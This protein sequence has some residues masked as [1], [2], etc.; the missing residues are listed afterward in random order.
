MLSSKFWVGLACGFLAQGCWGAEVVAFKDAAKIKSWDA[1]QDHLPQAVA[2]NVLQKEKFCLTWQ[3]LNQ[4]NPGLPELGRLATRTSKEIAGSSWSIGCETLDR[5]YGDWDAYKALL[6]LLGVKHARFFSGWAKTEQK[7]GVYDFAWLDRQ[8]RE[9]SEMG[10]KPWI[11]LSYG[12][13]VWGS[14]F[15]L[16]MRVSQITGNPEALEAWLRY[17]KACVERYR[18]IVTEWEI[19]NE[20]FGQDGDYAQLYFLTAK[21]I[22]SL[23]PNAQIYCTAFDNLSGYKAVL[24]RLKSEHALDLASRF[25]YHPYEP[26]PDDSWRTNRP[27][28]WSPLDLQA[29]V[30]SYSGR[31]VIM[32]GET[33]CPAQLEFA[34][35]LSNIEWSE[36]AQAKWNLRR[37]L[38]DAA[39][40]IPSSLFTIIDLQY[41]FMLQSF[42]LLR[43]NTL[44]EFVYRRPSWYA[45]RH[46]YALFDDETHPIAV[47]TTGHPEITRATFTRYGQPLHCLWYSSAVP[48]SRLAFDRQTITLPGEIT[49]PVWLELITGRIFAIPPETVSYTNGTTTLHNLPLWDSPIIVAS[50]TAIP[51]ET[52]WEKLTPYAIIDALYYRFQPDNPMKALPPPDSQPWMHLKT[53]DFLPCFDRYGQFRHRQWPGKIATDQDLCAA[54]QDEE[55]DLAAHPGPQDRSLFGGWK[56]GP[57]LQPTGRFRTHRDNQGRWWFVDPE[58]YLFWSFGPV[59]VTP[60]SAQTPLDG[61][62]SKPRHGVPLPPKDCLFA[63]LPPEPNAPEGTNVFSQF[64]TTR[65]ALL[66]PLYLARGV[67]R[68][69]DFSS[70][71]LYRKY[72]PDYR[73]HFAENAHRRLRSWGANTIANSSDLTI[74]LMDRTPYAER[75]E[76]Q[77]RPIAASHGM[78]G[79]FRD[80]WDDSFVQGVTDALSKCDRE[81]HDPWCIGFFVDNEINWGGA[82]DLARWTAMS[83]AD[84]PAK[85]ALLDWLL[86]RYHSIQSLNTAW[87]RRYADEV[88]FLA[89]VL[90]P[91]PAAEADLRAF[92]AVIVDRYFAR[93]REAVKAYDPNLLYLGCRFCGWARE[94]VIKA[95]ARYCDVVSYNIYRDSISNWRLPHHLDAPVLIG[96]FHFGATDRGPFGTGVCQARNQKER[97]AKMKRY[98][99]S[100]LLNPQIVGVHWHQFADQATSGRFDGE[101]LQVGWTD[102]C[103]TPYPIMRAALR[104]AAYPL[105]RTRSGRCPP[106]HP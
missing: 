20:P 45:M 68:T 8:I 64:W 83:P 58:G 9:C 36:Y 29:L 44:K 27:G 22:R 15:R 87:G 70:A 34:H 86:A 67:T 6:P 11:C 59:R 30:K 49:Q 26:N 41:T 94:E 79:K 88:D 19:W 37:A 73:R 28:R 55:K 56:Q 85:R 65:D 99:E 95:C 80:P 97:A 74:C 50:R 13:P 16:G 98:L 54:L 53:S 48:S 82:G 24:E 25:L 93:T 84:Q 72:G 61:D 100:A 101:G 5:D 62:T 43:S 75:V 46:I 40:S 96:E 77:S 71:N 66:W 52:H 106:A 10:I 21:A 2:T 90:P 105:Y 23:Q 42:G 91:P 76:C 39:R 63:D 89:T 104:E 7:R 4:L 35:A 18:S 47:T 1:W 78:W 33:G 103:D 57:R 14:D 17:C 69:Y 38:G 102:L 60:S 81:A 3:K 51:H 32:Q 92:T 31:F 12:N